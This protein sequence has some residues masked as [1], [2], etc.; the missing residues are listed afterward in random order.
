MSY[1]VDGESRMLFFPSGTHDLNGSAA[2]ALARSRETT[3]DFSRA[4]R[5]QLIISGIRRR[6]DQL[7]L[8]DADHLF[9]LV[10][11]AIR[12][13]DTDLGFTDALTY[14]RR[15]RDLGDLRRLVLSTDN[16]FHSTYSELHEEGLPVERAEGLEQDEI[17]QWILRPKNESWAGVRAFVEEWLTGGDPSA[18]EIFEDE[19]DTEAQVDLGPLEELTSQMPR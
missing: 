15:Y 13:T 2:L 8:T 1:E 16:V 10:T 6:I 12:Y 9:R 19:G 11:A 14:Y 3:S 4:R 17:G 7:A 18:D 5:Q